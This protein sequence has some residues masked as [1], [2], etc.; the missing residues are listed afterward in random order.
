MVHASRLPTILLPVLAAIVLPGC[1]DGSS[2]DGDSASSAVQTQ[3]D[4]ATTVGPRTGLSDAERARWCWPRSAPA[5]APTQL[6]LLIAT[7]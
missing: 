4:P 7:R 1:S 6:E 2:A 5:T 3:T